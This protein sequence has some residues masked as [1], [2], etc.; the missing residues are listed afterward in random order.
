MNINWKTVGKAA[1]PVASVVLAVASTI[2]GNTNQKA[3]MEET[4]AKK[5]T[6]ALSEKAKES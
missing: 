2:V 3:Q 4:V 5:V 1:L 6:E